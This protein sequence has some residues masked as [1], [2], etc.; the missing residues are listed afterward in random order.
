M[1]R[2]GAFVAGADDLNAIYYNPAGLVDA[3]NQLMLD[4]S[5]MFFQSAFTRQARIR[6]YDP[7]SGQPTGQEW[8]QTFPRAKG[9]AAVQPIPTFAVS[10]N[11][12]L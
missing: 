1:G 10:N 7:N 5:L 12:G 9:T 2:A 8:D 3:G 6:Q 4:A 11:F